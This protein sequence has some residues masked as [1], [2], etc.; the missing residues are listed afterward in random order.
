MPLTI[1]EEMMKQ[2]PFFQEGLEKGLKEGL[3]KGKLEAQ[4]E[5]I[6]NLYR[7]LRLPPNKIAKVLKVSEEFVRRVISEAEKS[8]MPPFFKQLKI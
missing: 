7:E 4:R 6:L 1:T 8:D 2:D 3:E 5:A